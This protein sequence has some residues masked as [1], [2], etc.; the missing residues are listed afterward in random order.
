MPRTSPSPAVVIIAV[1]AFAAAFA[2]SASGNDRAAPAQAAAPSVAVVD[3]DK[4]LAGLDEAAVVRDSLE[5]KK[6]EL[7]AALDTLQAS[8]DDRQ[9][10]L[11]DTAP[12]DRLAAEAELFR[13]MERGKA[14]A[15]A[16]T[17][18]MRAYEDKARADVGAKILDAV[19]SVAQSAGCMIVLNS[20]VPPPA[21][22]DAADSDKQLDIRAHRVLYASK[23]IDLTQQVIDYMNNR[24]NAGN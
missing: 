2:L 20:D 21:T 24:Y 7:K 5:V 19:N 9:K 3:T 15:N 12:G 17:L 8:I 16:S 13:L 11:E 22:K 4:V 18:I 10:R 1:L 23:Q 14:E 6:A